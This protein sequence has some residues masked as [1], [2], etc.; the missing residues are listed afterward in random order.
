MGWYT[1]PEK[2]PFTLKG[3]VLH[4]VV[5]TLHG[6]PTQTEGS[7]MGMNKALLAKP[8]RRI[9]TGDKELWAEMFRKDVS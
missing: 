8:L 5:S 4:D 2:H 7:K 6:Y 9:V 1:L 3:T